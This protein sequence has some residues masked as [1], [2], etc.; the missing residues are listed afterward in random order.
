[1]AR[2]RKIAPEGGAGKSGA[3]RERGE[4]ETYRA[5]RSADRTGEP[6]GQVAPTPEGGVGEP[7][8]FVIQKHAARRLHWDL[9]LEI[10]GVLRSW[11]IPRGPSLDPSVKR[12]AVETEDHPIDYLH[13]EGIIP[14]GNYGAGAMIVWDRGLWIPLEPVDAGYDAGKLLFELR[15]H[16]L[17][18]VWT[19]V[20]TKGTAKAADAGHDGKEWLLIKKPDGGAI[21]A[22]AATPDEASILSGLTIEELRSGSDRAKKIRAALEGTAPRRTIYPA[23]VQLMQAEPWPE[24]FTR[25]GWVFELKYD[26]YRL[27]ASKDDDGVQLRYRSGR[28][29]TDAFPEIGRTLAAFP[30]A[31]FVVDGE[32][33]VLD[34][35]ATPNFQRL[36]KRAL[37][38]RSRDI[39]RATREHPVTF[40]A[41]DLLGFDD[42]DL[43][44]LPLLERKRLLREILPQSGPVRF[45]DHIPTEG[46]MLMA[47][48]G[49]LGMEGILAKKADAPYIAG[50]SDMWRKIR[51]ECTD[52][53]VIVGY[54]EPEKQR[55]GFRSLHLACYEGDELVYV[56]RVGSGFSDADL[57][58]IRSQ[59]D[60]LV[61]EGPRCRGTDT[62]PKYNGHKWVRPELVAEVRYKHLTDDHLLRH[63][64][65]LR[66]RP[67]KAA[68]E[69]VRSCDEI[70]LDAEGPPDP[71]VIVDP[72]PKAPTPS[73]RNVV[74]SNPDKI[75]WPDEGY[76]KL[77]LVEYY[78][79]VWPWLGPYLVD[80]PLVLTRYPDGIAGKN[81][82]QKNAPPYVPDWIR[83]RTMWSEHAQREIEYFVCDEVDA[84][85][86]IANMASIPL[87]VWGSRLASLQHPDWT[88]LDLDPK[89]APFSHV[90]RIALH[91]HALCDSIGLPNY[92]KTSGSTGLHVL[93]PLGAQCTFE[94]C[95]MLAQVIAQLTAS[96]LRD[97][98][99]IERAMRARKGRVYVDFLQNGHGRL[100]VSPLCVRPRPGAPVSTPL[101][102]DEVNERLDQ[103]AFTIKNVPQRLERMGFDP[104]LP[105]LTERPDLQGALA[106][107]LHRL[108]GS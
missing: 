97:I 44:G 74:I 2:A 39:D 101:L 5:K 10:G 58:S 86:Y 107:L 81:F 33:C 99:T 89:D 41:F 90:V 108:G 83:T 91:I 94:Q 96:E 84:L 54:A 11:A 49:K 69:C 6:F 104:I 53:F 13:F 68:S 65:F 42:Y 24:P 55:T 8:N 28:N 63:P 16:K 82:Y 3:A 32:V 75:F 73:A 50:R 46:E 93:I 78:R 88:I 4:L 66:L 12:L 59:L 45:A 31:R 85:V 51:F 27:L 79:S 100:L 17:R 23:Q 19:L 87:H 20:R 22:G 72:E 18:G 1:M 26:G 60:E 64:V 98:A 9:R 7:R 76:T 71:P 14:Q 48:V 40:Y 77:D 61:V 102:W 43:R 37:L 38:L 56:G 62:V 80:R 36:Q 70:E 30:F 52:D 103:G 92:I 35:D 25:E 15:G 21:T 105:V 57:R 34:D 47:E 95:R 106:Q 29:A 67:D